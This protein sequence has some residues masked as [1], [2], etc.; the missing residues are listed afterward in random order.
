MNFVF[1]SD[2][3]M[4]QVDGGSPLEIPAL[5]L[6]KSRF[7][8]YNSQTLLR[9]YVKNSDEVK[10]VFKQLKEGKNSDYEVFL[11]KKL[12][13]YLHFATKDDRYHRIGQILLVPK[14]PKVFLFKY[15]TETSFQCLRPYP[16]ESTV[17]RPIHEVKPL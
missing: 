5:L 6:D 8:L 1:V 16:W 3:G 14:A 2:H 17:L 15:P 7:D 11:D 9:V 12:P 4:I 13:K 10:A